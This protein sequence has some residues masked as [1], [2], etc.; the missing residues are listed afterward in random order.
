MWTDIEDPDGIGFV[1]MVI[2]EFDKIF[3]KILNCG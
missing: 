3:L 1:I 2:V